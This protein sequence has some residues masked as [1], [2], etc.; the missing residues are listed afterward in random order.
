MDLFSQ[1]VLL[2]LVA[3]LAANDCGGRGCTEPTRL[4]ADLRKQPA[5]QQRAFRDAARIGVEAAST[6]A[7][8]VVIQTACMAEARRQCAAG[9][10]AEFT[11]FARID[12]PGFVR[13][14][15]AR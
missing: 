5:A 1:C 11:P 7:A 8:A 15:E 9:C 12:A 10:P 13:V 14:R 2:S 4:L 3:R 6:S